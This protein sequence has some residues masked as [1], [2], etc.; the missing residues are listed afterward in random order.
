MNKLV[1]FLFTFIIV[2]QITALGQV[3]YSGSSWY[4]SHNTQGTGI[5]VPQAITVDV[6]G[7]KIVTGWFDGD[8]DFDPGPSQFLL[9]ATGE[10]AFLLKLDPFGHFIWALKLGGNGYDGAYDVAVDS[11]GTIYCTGYYYG[12]VPYSTPFTTDSL[13]SAGDADAFL[14]AIDSAGDFLWVKSIGGASQDFGY[15]ISYGPTSAQGITLLGS[16]SGTADL[17]P[18][19]TVLNHVATGTSDVFICKTDVAGNLTWVGS[20]GG[21]GSYVYGS[22][23]AVDASGYVHVTG[24]FQGSV[25]FDPGA[26][27]S[28]LV[29][30]GPAPGGDDAYILKLNASGNYVWARQAGGPDYTYSHSISLDSRNGDIYYGGRFSGIT[31]FDPGPATFS[32]TPPSD[33]LF[34]SK[35]DSAGNFSWA[36][37]IHTS[38]GSVDSRCTVIFSENR[39]ACH[40]S[41]VYSGGVDM[42][43]GPGVAYA[44]SMGFDDIFIMYLDSSGTYRWVKQLGDLDNEAGVVMALDPTLNHAPCISGWFSSPSLNFGNRYLFNSAGGLS[45]FVA[46]LN[47]VVLGSESVENKSPLSVFPVPAKHEIHVGG[48]YMNPGMSY[49]WIIMD[50]QGKKILSGFCIPDSKPDEAIDVSKLVPG[51][52]FLRL[53]GSEVRTARFTILR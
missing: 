52:Y 53:E 46:E 49:R 12:V 42:D 37:S 41:G 8:V 3:L 31:D 17:D 43:P 18:G 14:A 23:L 26:S 21:A 7:N 24:Y 50:L 13:V 11:S 27:S 5:A 35:L 28:V 47:Y 15:A 51:T 2:G 44:G 48:M 30:S 32:L 36:K 29:S 45:L 39:N 6:D 34:I 19:T 33:A 38:S 40:V 22:D 4:W 16:F 20:V 1:L 9:S 25:D 10:D